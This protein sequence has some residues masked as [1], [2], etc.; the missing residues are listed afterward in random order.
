[1]SPLSNVN[2][3]QHVRRRVSCVVVDWT[4]Q[5]GVM[6][7][8][9]EQVQHFFLQRPYCYFTLHKELV[10]RSFVYSENLLPQPLYSPI[11]NVIPT[12]E[13][14]SSAILVITI[15]GY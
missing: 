6:G 1:M 2:Q 14:C 9:P 11:V 15:V 12:P 13:V 5:H 3:Y 10:Y 8:K 7:Q 4:P